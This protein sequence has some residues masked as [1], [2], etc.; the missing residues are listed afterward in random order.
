MN[1]R[2]R[3]EE[4]IRKR[5]RFTAGSTLRNRFLADV[6]RAQEQSKQTESAPHGAG[7]RR[8][9]MQSPITRPAS[10]AALIAVAVLSV[11][12]WVRLSPAA[13]ALEQTFQALQNVRFLHIVQRDAAGQIADERWIEI[14]DDGYQVRYRQDNPAPRDFGVI[15]DGKSTAVYHRDKNG[16]VL[17]DRQDKQYSWVVELGEAFD[18]LRQKGK[19]LQENADYKGR[20]VHR[21]WWPFLNAECFIDP[22]TRLPIAIGSV[23]LSY[24]I[25]PAGA[26]EI[27][28][29]EGYAVLDKRPGAAS[30]VAP[31]WFQEDEEAEKQKRQCFNRGVRALMAGD[32]A[33]AAEQLEQ[34]LGSDSWRAF[35]LGH[36]YCGLGKYDLAIENYNKLYMMFGDNAMQTIPMCNYARG[37]AYARSGRLEAAQKNLRACLPAMVMTL[38]TP[39]GGMMFEYADSPRIRLG[40]YQPG[41]HEIVIQMIN[42]LRLITGQDFGYDPNATD[43]QNEAAISAWEQWF[44]ND[45]Q[46]RFTPDAKGL[47]ILAE[48]IYKLG[49]GRKSNLEIASQY[50]REWLEQITSPTAW[51]KI[52]FALY[53]AKR[54][55]EALAAFEKMQE[56]ANADPHTQTTA[57]IW[58]GHMLD[59]L[60]RR[61][62]AVTKYQTIAD[63]RLKSGTA[64]AQYGLSYT[65]SSYAKERM[66]VPFAHIENL[67]EN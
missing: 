8:I 60:G 67:D 66:S 12:F 38:R 63:A 16:V 48:W 41:D 53:D 51:Q 47:P 19:I 64:H 61:S 11:S 30:T 65:F 34:S 5:L 2:N 6:L 1:P 32:Y 14:G 7:L 52:G 21:V 20:K 50:R 55:D 46:I 49:W 13:Y 24:E 58:Q 26:F 10:V 23:E 27:V 57:I 15:E 39:S 59:L 37:I 31:D 29:P 40:L 3:V 18:N 4:T 22:G 45:G 42:R 56:T 33:Q 44:K 9:I 36:A 35:W 17:Y 54:Y 28:I 62:E 43:A 25:P